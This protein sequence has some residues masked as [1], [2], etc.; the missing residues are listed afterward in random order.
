MPVCRH[1][2]EPALCLVANNGLITFRFKM[3][4]CCMLIRLAF[5]PLWS[6]AQATWE[7]GIAGRFAAYA[8]D[9][10]AEKFFDLDNRDILVG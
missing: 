7:V 5:A 3:R 4:Q 9:V 10:N 2:L 6:V 8:G 1:L